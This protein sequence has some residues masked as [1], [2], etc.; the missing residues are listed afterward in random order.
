MIKR[1][2]YVT[3]DDNAGGF[4]VRYSMPHLTIHEKARVLEK[5]LQ[6]YFKT[7]KRSV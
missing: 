2:I 7:G 4:I 1:S 3:P 6:R 5:L